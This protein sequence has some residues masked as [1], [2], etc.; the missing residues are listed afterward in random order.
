MQ[1][2]QANKRQIRRPKALLVTK[3]REKEQNKHKQEIL[4]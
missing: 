1:L 2:Q 4:Q 3:E